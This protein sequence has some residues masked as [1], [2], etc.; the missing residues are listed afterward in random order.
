MSDLTISE[1]KELLKLSRE[2]IIYYMENKKYPEYTNLNKKFDES[3]GV[4]VTLHMD[5]ALRGCIGH[6]LPV[7]SLYK[8]VMENSVSSAFEDPRFSSLSK[9][10]INKIDIEI[11]VLSIPKEVNTY[12]DV[13]V[14]IDG[15]II[16]KGFNRGLLL[17]QVP[18]EQG[19]GLEEYISYGCLKAGL[20]KDQWREGVKIETF[21][22]EVFGEKEI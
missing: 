21:N 17:P 2:T 9:D 15:I 18:V 7:L 22:A 6:P 13:K 4:F 14:G 1:K 20:D 3:R 19:W 11:S 10:E 5:G 12:K 8:S 16:S